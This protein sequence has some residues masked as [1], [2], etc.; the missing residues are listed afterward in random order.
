MTGSVDMTIRMDMSG[1]VNMVI[2]SVVTLF[3]MNGFD[4]VVSVNIGVQ[5]V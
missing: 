3:N 1:S 2:S 4:I 5:E